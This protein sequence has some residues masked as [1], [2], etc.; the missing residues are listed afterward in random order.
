MKLMKQMDPG[1][2]ERHCAAVQAQARRLG[3][4]SHY[5]SSVTDPYQPVERELRITSGL[6]ELMAERHE[7]KLV[8]QTRSPLVVR[9]CDLFR[10][11][12]GNGGR[13]QVNMTV[14]T[15]DEDVRR[16]FEPFCPSNPRRLE[17]IKKVQDAGIA[18]CITMTPLLSVSSSGDFANELIDNGVRKFTAQPFHFVRGKFA[19]GTRDGALDM[20]SKKLGRGRSNFGKE[21]LK[22]TGSSL[23][24]STIGCW[25]TDCQNWEERART[26]SARPSNRARPNAAAHYCL[27]KPLALVRPRV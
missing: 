7:S 20:M 8:T 13:V 24:Y 11:I 5:M 10:R 3:R 22:L 26:A 17:A 4:Q 15:D 1:Q 16:T 23:N 27:E 6:L 19:A 2:R 21:Y 25:T 12:E 14:T 18:T 9:D